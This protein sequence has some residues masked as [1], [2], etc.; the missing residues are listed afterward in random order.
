MTVVI[1]DVRTAI[2]DRP[3]IVPP[4]SSPPEVLGVGDGSTT[5]FFMRSENAILPP[6]GPVLIFFGT[7]TSGSTPMMIYTQISNADATY[8]WAF[9]SSAFGVG[10]LNFNYAPPVGTTVL[11][12]YTIT[13]FTDEEITNYIAR[14]NSY[15]TDRLNLMGIAY[16]MIG[17][18]LMNDD[19]FRIYTLGDTKS[20]PTVVR[21]ALSA[22]QGQIFKELSDQAAT[23]SPAMMISYG[24]PTRYIR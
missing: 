12:R 11:A 22:Q 18:M 19:K 15:Q 24:H 7:M 2:Q 9:G 23:S 17:A 4:T 10:L 6:D 16:D 14:A 21:A 8:G 5:S 1:S 13:A 20:D 3:K